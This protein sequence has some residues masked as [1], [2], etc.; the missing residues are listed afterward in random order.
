LLHLCNT[1]GWR[2]AKSIRGSVFCAPGWN[3]AGHGKRRKSVKFVVGMQHT[4]TTFR[5]IPQTPKK[6]ADACD[7]CFTPVAPR[8]RLQ[9]VNDQ[10]AGGIRQSAGFLGK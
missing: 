4:P 7:F 2:R 5:G 1:D 10:T 3:V 8:S 9:L 6:S